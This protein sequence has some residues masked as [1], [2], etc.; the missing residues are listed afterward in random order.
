MTAQIML[1]VYGLPGQLLILKGPDMKHQ[2]V[3]ILKVYVWI[4]F[5]EKH[6]VISPLGG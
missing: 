6:M 2:S 1:L 5:K 3:S 4:E